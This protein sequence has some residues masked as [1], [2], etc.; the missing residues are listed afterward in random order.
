MSIKTAIIQVRLSEEFKE[1]VQDKARARGQNVTQ[2]VLELLKDDI[3]GKRPGQPAKRK[4]R[5]H[6]LELRHG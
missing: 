5:Q 6:E 2:Y 3:Y 4:E 1:A